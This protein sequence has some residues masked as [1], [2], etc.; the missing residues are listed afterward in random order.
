[1]LITLGTALCFQSYNL[2]F[3]GNYGF[4]THAFLIINLG[5]SVVCCLFVVMRENLYLKMSKNRGTA[6]ATDN[7][8]STGRYK[9]VI[10]EC[11]LIMIHP[12][13]FFVGWKEH[14][15]N[16]SLQQGI[17]YYVNDYFQ[18]LSLVRFTYFLTSV[19]N[20]SIWKSRSAHRVCKLYECE[21]GSKFAIRAL[22][23]VNPSVFN[24]VLFTATMILFTHG[25]RVAEA[26]ISRVL[27]EMDDFSFINSLW[28]VTM[29]MTTGKFRILF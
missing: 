2:E 11:I 18:I 25:M 27:S 28:A 8:A 19:L 22:M 6:K 23:K 26:P 24:T 29:T 17:Y 13:P 12:S 15:F 20:I 14:V 5:F 21:G 4:T 16:E 1:M 7:L 10:L 9:L 3:D